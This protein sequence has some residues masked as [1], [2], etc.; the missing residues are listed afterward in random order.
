MCHNCISLYAPT[1]SASNKDKDDLYDQLNVV[2]ITVPS[3]DVKTLIGDFNA[4]NG[5]DTS[6]FENVMGKNHWGNAQITKND[7]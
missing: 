5:L 2:L 1:E 4:R 7:C 6:G 3:H